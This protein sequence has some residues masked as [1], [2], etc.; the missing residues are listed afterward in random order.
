VLRQNLTLHYP[1]TALTGGRNTDQCYHLEDLGKTL[2]LTPQSIL[3]DLPARIFYLVSWPK[4]PYWV[5]V[6]ELELA[7]ELS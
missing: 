7:L 2:L 3:T 1:L 6:L 4:I 5:I